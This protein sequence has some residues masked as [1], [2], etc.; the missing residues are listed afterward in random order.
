MEW[1][2][3]II[4]FQERWA[5]LFDTVGLETV[6]TVKEVPLYPPPFS[7]LFGR[8]LHFISLLRKKG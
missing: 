7:L 6:K 4:T 3:H 5:N 1:R 2:F 8:G